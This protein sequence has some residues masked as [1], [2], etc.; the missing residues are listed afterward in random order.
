MTEAFGCWKWEEKENINF[1]VKNNGAPYSVHKNLN[2]VG[3]VGYIRLGLLPLVLFMIV[4]III[5]LYVV[6]IHN[7]C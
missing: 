3:T 1:R 6:C 4:I 5:T 2:E 7:A